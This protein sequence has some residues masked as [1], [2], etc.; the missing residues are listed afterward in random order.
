M[1]NEMQYAVNALVAPDTATTDRLFLLERT[2]SLSEEQG[3]L[4]SEIDRLSTD[5]A[6]KRSRLESLRQT[7][8]YGS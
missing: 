1:K 7:L 4:Q 3:R 2:K 5:L 8:A 6:A